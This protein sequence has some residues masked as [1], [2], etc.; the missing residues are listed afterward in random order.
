MPTVTLSTLRSRVYSHLED[1][2]A[3][4]TQAE[5]D[6]AINDAIRV[7]NLFTGFIQATATVTSVNTGA[8]YSVPSAILIPTRVAFL[9]RPLGRASFRAMGR[10]RRH[11]LRE[12]TETEQSSVE[13]WIPMGLSKFAIHPYDAVGGRAIT[14]TGVAEPAPLVNAGDETQ[15]PT[16]FQDALE[17]YAAHGLLLK[18]G[19]MASR[20]GMTQYQSF[21]SRMRDLR[22]YQTNVNPVFFVEIEQ[23]K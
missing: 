16:E 8:I 1:N 15:Y 21:L 3:F 18:A 12:S 7:L 13:R 4:Y 14:V 11:W 5:V 22:R 10:S 20:A 17:L 9:G 19:G 6:D 2:T 23:E